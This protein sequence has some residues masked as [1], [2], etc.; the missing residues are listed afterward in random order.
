MIRGVDTGRLDMRKPRKSYHFDEDVDNIL[1]Q[2]AKFT[3]RT[4]SDLINDAIKQQYSKAAKL[5]DEDRKML[6]TLAKQ[7]IPLFFKS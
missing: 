6:E 4:K 1:N 7:F 3:G 2:M 5:T